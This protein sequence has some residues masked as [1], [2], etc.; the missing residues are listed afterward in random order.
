M[1]TV[2]ASRPDRIAEAL[3]WISGHLDEL[4]IPFQVAGGLAA[5]A[6]GVER[7]LHDIDLYVPGG[8]LDRLIPRVQ[9]HHSHGP[10]RYLDQHW[11]CYFLEVHRAG[12]EI[13]LAEAPKTRYRKDPDS[14]WH[15]AEVDFDAPVHREV[16]G[17]KVPVMPVEVLV[18]YKRRLDRPVDREDVEALTRGG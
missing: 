16:F 1:E 6:H 17:V 13:E 14:P 8:A 4:G 15:E 10:L 11:D 9:D 12:E 3:R 7:E 5:L 18:R 2:E